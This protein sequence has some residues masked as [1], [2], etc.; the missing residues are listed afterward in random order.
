MKAERAALQKRWSRA[1]KYGEQLLSASSA[2]DQ[3]T[4]PRYINFLKT[5]NSYYDKAGRLKEIPLRL[6]QAYRL[7]S[8]SLGPDHPTTTKSRALYYKL[9][10]SQ[11]QYTRAIPLMEENIDISKTDYAILGHLLRLYSLY[12]LTG[13]YEKEQETLINLL[14]LNTRL[15]GEADDGNI[16]FISDLANNYC[17]QKKFRAFNQLMKVHKLKF[18]C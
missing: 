13:Q 11:N 5:L 4:Y 7:S 3:K 10:I 2:L 1:I 15:Y 14:K 18:V 9:L 8:Q 16:G 6:E 12:A 17:R